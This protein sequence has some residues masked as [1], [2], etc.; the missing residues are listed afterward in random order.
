[1]LCS[2]PTGGPGYDGHFILTKLMVSHDLSLS[3]ITNQTGFGQRDLH[4]T[5]AFERAMNRRCQTQVGFQSGN[6]RYHHFNLT[7]SV[8]LFCKTEQEKIKNWRFFD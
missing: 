6:L 5:Y 1:M 2:L 3:P 8:K 4:S 7:D